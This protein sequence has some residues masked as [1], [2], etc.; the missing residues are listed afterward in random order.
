MSSL[1]VAILAAL[2]WNGRADELEKPTL[3]VFLQSNGIAE[4]RRIVNPILVK[5]VTSTLIPD[6]S[7]GFAGIDIDISEIKLTEFTLGEQEVLNVPPSAVYIVSSNMTA[8]A[9]MAWRYKD[10]AIDI[11]GNA[12]DLMSDMSLGIVLDI[13]SLEHRL[14]LDIIECTVKIG[15]LKIQLSGTSSFYEKLVELLNSPITNLFESQIGSEIKTLANQIIAKYLPDVPLQVNVSVESATVHAYFG[16]VSFGNVHGLYG[17]KYGN[18]HFSGSGSSYQTASLSFGVSAY[19]SIS[20]TGY[21]SPQNTGKYSIRMHYKQRS[22]VTFV[23]KSEG[24]LEMHN[25]GMCWPEYHT[26]Y[27][28]AV[29]LLAHA[30]YPLQLEYQSGCG[31][32]HVELTACFESTNNCTAIDSLSLYAEPTSLGIP[33]VVHSDAIVASSAFNVFYQTQTIP[34]NN[35]V[36]SL[37]NTLPS[38]FDLASD[39]IAVYVDEYVFNSALTAFSEAGL[40]TVLVNNSVIPPSLKSFFQFNTTFFKSYVPSLYEKY[41]NMAMTIDVGPFVHP[42]LVVLPSPVGLLGSFSFVL[43]VYVAEEQKLIPAFGLIANLTVSG[44]AKMNGSNITAN[45]EMKGFNVTLSWA[46]IDV[47]QTSV[48]NLKSFMGSMINLVALPAINFKL[49]QG[50]PIP[51]FDGLTIVNPR[52]TYYNGY[53]GVTAAFK[54]EI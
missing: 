10:G 25:P 42:T 41:P 39:M 2:C 47:N 5:T 35:S 43:D 30:F 7:F 14:I 16:L 49:N 45:V 37:P 34:S 15:T 44:M 4:I 33:V 31:G 11:S 24:G 50:I 17:K 32:G 52:F 38:S 9:T 12:T 29:P 22:R 54:I 26:D 28:E 8:H 13:T 1:L 6:Q 21:F 3:Q 48:D 40:F 51:A 18:N 46:K 27:T 23:G 20:I 53:I 36:H 19:D